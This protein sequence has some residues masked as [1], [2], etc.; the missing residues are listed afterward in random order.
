MYRF[1]LKGNSM[2]LWFYGFYI[3]MYRKAIVKVTFWR[4]STERHGFIT[5]VTETIANQN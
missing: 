3:C 5:R 1:V 2:I 4:L